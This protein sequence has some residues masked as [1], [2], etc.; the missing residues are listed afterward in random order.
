M[1]EVNVISMVCACGKTLKAPATAVGKKARCRS[2][3]NTFVV[4]PPEEVAAP[5][6]PDPDAMYELAEPAR[7]APEQTSGAVC[8]QCGAGMDGN[9]VLCVNCGFNTKTGKSIAVADKPAAGKA[10]KPGKLL[11]NADKPVDYMAPDGSLVLGV[12]ISAVFALVAS[13]LWIAVAWLTGFAIGWIAIIIGAA[14]GVGMQ[15]GHKGYSHTGGIVASLM[16][17]FAIFVAKV[18]VLEIVLSRSPIP[19]SISHLNQAAL[20][21]YF[22]NPIGLIIIAI[23]VGAAY[24]TA[25]GSSR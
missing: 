13:I 10:G 14:A 12:I 17:I 1:T 6:E 7:S 16:T 18:V 8:P 20:L 9:A 3:G 19:L 11:K 24:R 5:E 21:Y 22:F 2:C 23:G 4:T 25:N 15:I